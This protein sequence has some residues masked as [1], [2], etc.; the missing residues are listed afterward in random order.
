MDPVDEYTNAPEVY[1]A[2]EEA[3][4]PAVSSKRSVHSRRS[5]SLGDFFNNAVHSG[6]EKASQMQHS[7]ASRLKS[8]S[9]RKQSVEEEYP[10]EEYLEEQSYNEDYYEEPAVSENE[11]VYVDD[12]AEQPEQAA[13]PSVTTSISPIDVS[14]FMDN[15]EFDDEEEP[16]RRIDDNVVN[17]GSF[18]DSND[19]STARIPA[20]RVQEEMKS[21]SY[22]YSDEVQG[23]EY[24]EEPLERT[25]PRPAVASPIVGMEEM[26]SPVSPV[27]EQADHSRQVIVLPDVTPARS[28]SGENLRQRAPMAEVN[29]PPQAVNRCFP[30]CFLVLMEI[31]MRLA[32][33]LQREASTSL[34]LIRARSR[35]CLQLALFRL[36]VALAHSPL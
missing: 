36:L 34:R 29:A 9:S 18:H 32:Q 16:I 19:E 14:Q 24:A 20:G 1:P 25:A 21:Y 33:R 17:M 28:A 7:F 11:E 8:I 30:T 15:E 12:P 3:S 31:L 22:G 13:S 2:N 4:R 10:A 23:R 6:S 27:V 26:V 35:Q 5:G